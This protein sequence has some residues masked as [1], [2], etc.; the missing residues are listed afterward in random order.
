MRGTLTKAVDR[1]QR[2]R[3]TGG[4][5]APISQSTGKI[6]PI[7]NITQCPLRMHITPIVMMSTK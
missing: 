4:M 5:I 1:V 7:R 6:S 3:R 2:Y